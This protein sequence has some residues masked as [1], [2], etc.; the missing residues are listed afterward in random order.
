[1]KWG[2]VGRTPR[3]VRLDY[4]GHPLPLEAG[5]HARAQI[6]TVLGDPP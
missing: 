4:K 1:V 3:P 5:A 2:V 6:L